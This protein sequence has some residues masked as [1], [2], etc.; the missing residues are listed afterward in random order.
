[1]SAFG[2][3]FPFGDVPSIKEALREAKRAKVYQEDCFKNDYGQMRN[4]S[5]FNS[6]SELY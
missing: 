5:D 2:L 4:G 1:M 6:A 3:I